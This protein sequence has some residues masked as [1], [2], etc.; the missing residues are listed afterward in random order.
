MGPRRA[1]AGVECLG[2]AES[3]A[4]S[5]RLPLDRLPLGPR[6]GTPGRRPRL[7]RALCLPDARPRPRWIPLG[8]LLRRTHP[9]VWR[10][11]PPPPPH[12]LLVPLRRPILS[13]TCC[14][15]RVYPLCQRRTLLI[16]ILLLTLL[17]HCSH[18]CVC[19]H[20]LCHTTALPT[21]LNL[22]PV[23]TD[24][25]PVA[26]CGNNVCQCGF[27]FGQD[28]GENREVFGVVAAK[29]GLGGDDPVVVALDLGEVEKGD[30]DGVKGDLDRMRVG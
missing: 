9:H 7:G 16:V 18:P 11:P 25:G 21:L 29:V 14:R 20:P 23:P 30:V 17:T 28:V 4:S 2:D 24:P 8:C 27:H 5:L 19:S 12:P 13:Q 10:L 6:V 15:R 3:Q 1:Q 26:F 22:P